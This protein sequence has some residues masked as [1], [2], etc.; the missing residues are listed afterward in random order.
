M[1]QIEELEEGMYRLVVSKDEL[2]MVTSALDDFEGHEDAN[3]DPEE[4]D[5]VEDLNHVLQSEPRGVD[6]TWIRFRVSP[7]TRCDVC[8]ETDRELRSDGNHEDWFQIESHGPD[9]N[10]DS[11]FVRVCGE[12][13]LKIF[14]KEGGVVL[15]RELRD[16]RRF[17]QKALSGVAAM[18]MVMAWG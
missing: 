6:V 12:C 3:G 14:R 7:K 4:A 11:V 18:A 1:P 13:M 10:H 16:L 15:P 5:R 8:G 17:D 9:L 2:R